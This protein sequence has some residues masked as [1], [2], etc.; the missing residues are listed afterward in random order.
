MIPVNEP[1]LVNSYDLSRVCGGDP[2]AKEDED[3]T[4]KFVPRMRG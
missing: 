3:E 2:L 1:V 4:A